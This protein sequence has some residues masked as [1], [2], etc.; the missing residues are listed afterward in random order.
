MGLA[1]K[2]PPAAASG[3]KIRIQP[4]APSVD[5]AQFLNCDWLNSIFKNCKSVDTLSVEQADAEP[6]QFISKM[7][8]VNNK[9]E[10]LTARAATCRMSFIS[11]SLAFDKSIDAATV[12]LGG[13]DND[14]NL[15]KEP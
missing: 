6:F 12:F 5:C 4:P 14:L 11:F 8:T 7:S 15:N 3:H 9:K 2:F 1:F 13:V 10:K